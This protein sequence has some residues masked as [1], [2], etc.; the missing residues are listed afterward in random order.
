M[1]NLE[2]SQ[3]LT[4]IQR[5]EAEKYVMQLKMF[6]YAFMQ[7]EKKME[8]LQPYLTLIYGDRERAEDDLKMAAWK[9]SIESERRKMGI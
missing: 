4:I 1:S 9:A 3:V 6:D 2:I 7:I 8:F 5:R